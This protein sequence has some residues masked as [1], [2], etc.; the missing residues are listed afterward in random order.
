MTERDKSKLP[1]TDI[2]LLKSIE[3]KTIRENEEWW[4]S[5][6]NVHYE[7]IIWIRREGTLAHERDELLRKHWNCS[8]YRRS[9]GLD[10]VKEGVWRVG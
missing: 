9:R 3:G 7:F 6:W 1:D 2:R 8:W 5:K 10:Q 4:Y